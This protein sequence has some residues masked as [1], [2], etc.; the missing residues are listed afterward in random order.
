MVT[1]NDVN[2]LNSMPLDDLYQLF[3]DVKEEM[4]QVQ[5]SQKDGEEQ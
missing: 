4:A 2:V 3:E 1:A 5:S